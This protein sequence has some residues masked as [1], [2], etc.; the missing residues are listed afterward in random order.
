MKSNAVKQMERALDLLLP[1][2][3]DEFFLQAELSLY[4]REKATKYLI[5][6]THSGLQV[7]LGKHSTAL[8]AA[9]LISYVSTLAQT[10][11]H[12][13][14][15]LQRRNETVLINATERGTSVR[16]EK[17][18]GNQ[19]AETDD[20]LRAVDSAVLLRVLGFTD[21]KGEVRPGE[22]R[23]YNQINQY[24][25][26]AAP[27]LRHL[28]EQSGTF[29]VIDAACGKSP[30]SFVLNFYLTQV[31]RCKVHVVGIDISAGVIATANRL[32]DELGYR[33]AE[34][35][36]SSVADYH[37]DQPYPVGLVVSL[38]A[39][40]TA[41]DEALAAGVRWQ[42]AANIVV[43]CCQRELLGQ[44]HPDG[45]ADPLA[46][47]FRQGLLKARLA[48]LLTDTVRCLAL[49]ANGYAVS[50][51][52]FCSPLDTPKNL[53]LRAIKT[54]DPAAAQQ[55]RQEYLLLHQ[56][57]GINPSVLGRLFD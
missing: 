43:P 13:E 36:T 33:N 53:M 55:A 32:R 31:L 3:T 14:I 27:V 45:A 18:L 42:A 29:T 57:Y 46:P 25:K 7:R 16:M 39:C 47:V 35:L 10:A 40:D 30:L 24:L 23:K 26:A 4:N 51:Q 37:Y 21:S 38:H 34:Y 2:F 54:P 56:H 15:S 52:E 6:A 5:V 28:A 9:D 20:P 44:I 48:D 12:L 41:T 22:M 19:A 50:V 11:D 49:Q 17:P 8:S 1:R